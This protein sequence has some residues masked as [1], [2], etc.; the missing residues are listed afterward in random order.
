MGQVTTSSDSNEPS[1]DRKSMTG[2]ALAISVAIVT[3]TIMAFVAIR[4]GPHPSVPASNLSAIFQSQV[5]SFA[6]SAADPQE[7]QAL[8]DCQAKYENVRGQAVRMA[9]RKA[10][11]RGWFEGL[12]HAASSLALLASFAISFLGAAKGIELSSE[13]TKEQL[14]AI[15][16]Q[17]TKLRKRVLTLSA[18]A[19]LAAA[20]GDRLSAQSSKTSGEGRDIVHVIETADSEVQHALGANDIR[21]AANHLELAIS[22]Q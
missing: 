21:S 16:R 12:G 2:V 13:P 10:T 22:Q 5:L 15:G 4:P 8:L 14:K 1:R 3:A 17:N 18:L 7:H 19:A 9:Q 6:P 20:S 11:L